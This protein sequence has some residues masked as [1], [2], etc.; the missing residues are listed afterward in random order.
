MEIYLSDKEDQEYRKVIEIDG[1]LTEPSQNPTFAQQVQFEVSLHKEPLL[2]PFLVVE[3]KD[4]SKLTIL[5]N[6]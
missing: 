5:G 4:K 3:T 6:Q 1:G 2:W